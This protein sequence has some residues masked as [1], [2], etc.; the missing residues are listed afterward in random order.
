MNMLH[1]LVNRFFLKRVL[2]RTLLLF[3]IIAVFGSFHSAFSSSRVSLPT[4]IIPMIGKPK[5][6]LVLF[7]YHRAEWSDNV[8]KGIESVFSSY[9]DVHFFYEY[10]DTKKLK[11]EEYFETLRK[12]YTEKYTNS[13]IDLVISV[14]NNALDLLVE[15]SQTLLPDTPVVFCG[16]NDY[17]PTLH[18][19]RPGVTG[20]VEYG[21]FTDTLKIAFRARPNATK[22]YIISD[23]TETGLSNTRELVAALS[24]VAP[25]TQAVLTNRMSYKELSTTLQNADPQEVSFFVSFWKDGT[26]MNIE[27]WQLDAIFRT[28][29]IPVFGRSEW[30][31][32]HGMVGGKCVT[33]F[34]QGEA[35]ARFAVQILG[36]TSVTDLPV[37][38]KS[39]N[40]YLFDYQMMKHYLIDEDIFPDQSIGFN[41]PESFFRVSRTVGT[42][43]LIFSLLL[44]AALVVLVVNV[45]LRKKAEKALRESESRY[46]GMIEN[47]QDTFYRTDAQGILIFISSSGAR[48]LGYDS[49]QEMIGRPYAS[50]WKF[51]EE[52]QKMLEIIKRDGVVH[53]YEIIMVRKD[54]SPALVSTTSSFYYDKDGQI[55]GVEGVFRDISDRKRAEEERLSLEKQLLHAQKLESLGIL[56]GGI[57]HDYNNLLTVIMGNA[58]LALMR[59]NPESPAVGNLHNIEEATA[60]AADLANQM[61]AYSGKGKFIVESLDLNRLLE[62]MLHML[63]ISISKKAV[64]RFNQN[65]PLPQV[66]ADATQMRQIIMNLVINASEAIG[67]K[68]GVI[69]I[70]TGCIDCDLSYLKDD[71]LDENISAGLYVYL[72]IADTGCGMDKE[73][74]AKLFDPFFTTK[75]TGRGLGMAA[76]L[77]IV[78]S[79]KGAI[80]VDSEVDKGTLFKV[81]LPASK[82]PA[83]LINIKKYTDDWKGSGTVLLVDDEESVRSICFEMLKELGFETITA[84]DGREAVEQFKNNPSISFVI[85]DLTMPHMDG[86]QCFRELRQ[87]QPDIKVIMSSGF[88]EDTVTQKFVGKGLAGFIQKPYKLRVLKEAIRGLTEVID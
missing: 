72:D 51:S 84:N 71:W 76:V 37:D 45:Q 36:G 26:G 9:E 82:K 85:L 59:L 30:M 42:I 73:T 1:F 10:M 68:S 25:G 23:Q 32:N 6:I 70:T 52:R 7:S 28:S 87:L 78:R 19:A 4:D 46:R 41:L 2:P 61:L 33:G 79:H 18:S 12:I 77:G 24:T 11:T 27:S 3:L 48:L 66:E 8:Q 5:N 60:R 40:Q 65:Q 29:P 17:K 50:F 58:E 53:D 63:E 13:H 20:V 83:A 86:E 64:L 56:A 69:T 44:L 21:D 31:I 57:A 54:G 88:S 34:A 80:K 35:A 43:V 74:M 22:L 75:F 49:S 55:L 62:E 16:V 47:I 38:T 81:L 67:D 39:P 15:N 14:D